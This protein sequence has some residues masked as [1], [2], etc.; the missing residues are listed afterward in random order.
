MRRLVPQSS[1][2]IRLTQA[3]QAARFD[4]VAMLDVNKGAPE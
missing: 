2:I 1:S 3:I 4:S